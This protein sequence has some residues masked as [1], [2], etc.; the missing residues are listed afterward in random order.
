MS[1]LALSSLAHD[2]QEVEQS[3]VGLGTVCGMAGAGRGQGW[4]GVEG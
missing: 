2:G 1:P 3:R 4:D